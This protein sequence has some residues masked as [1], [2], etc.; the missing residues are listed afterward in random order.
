MN[1]RPARLVFAPFATAL[2]FSLVGASPALAQSKQPPPSEEARKSGAEFLAGLKFDKTLCKTHRFGVY[3]GDRN[4][5]QVEITVAPAIK[6][7]GAAYRVSLRQTFRL[8][9]LKTTQLEE[10]LL[11]AGFARIKSSRAIDRTGQL[12]TFGV[13]RQGEGW[14]YFGKSGGERQAAVFA[15]KTQDHS[16]LVSRL[17]LAQV[18]ARRAKPARFDLRGIAWPD[19]ESFVASPR[20]VPSTNRLT[21]QL[22]K[23]GAHEHRGKKLQAREVSVSGDE[24]G[25][26][27]IVTLGLKGELLAFHFDGDSRVNVLGDRTEAKAPLPGLEDKDLAACRKLVELWI[28]VGLREKKSKAL[29]SHVDWAS[30]AKGAGKKH[31]RLAGLGPAELESAF[32]ERLRTP[33]PL[34]SALGSGHLKGMLLV[35]RAKDGGPRVEFLGSFGDSAFRFRKKGAAWQIVQ[36]PFDPPWRL[37]AQPR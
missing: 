36:M 8:G 31:K 5:G 21:F 27:L 12:T 9:V 30:I 13:V 2:A 19:P 18:L 23:V 32:L 20:F 15:D 24:Y 11:D 28:E 6:G 35:D 33:A 7:S 17:L 1:D 34:Y 14:A 10:H 25:R 16:D 37:P 29:S 26:G 4:A 22:G 3:M